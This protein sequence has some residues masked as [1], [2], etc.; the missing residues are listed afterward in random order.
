[1]TT[2]SNEHFGARAPFCVLEGGIPWGVLPLF[3]PPIRLA[4]LAYYVIVTLTLCGASDKVLVH[5]YYHSMCCL[6]LT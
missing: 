5:S 1:M 2:L 4:M 6:K 3:P